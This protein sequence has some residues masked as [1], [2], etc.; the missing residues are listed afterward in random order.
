M[1]QEEQNAFPEQPQLHIQ[2]TVEPQAQ[3]VAEQ[4]SVE[5]QPAFEQQPVEQQ[6]AFEQPMPAQPA[7][8]PFDP[9]MIPAQPQQ[10]VD[11]AAPQPQAAS[12]PPTP[13]THTSNYPTYEEVAAQQ[14]SRAAAQQEKAR[15]GVSVPAA[16]IIAI[17]VAIIASLV[18][19]Y[20][21][22]FDPT[23][24]FS[25]KEQPAKSESVTEIAKPLVNQDLDQNLANAVAE[26]A[27]PSVV[28]IYTYTEQR[29]YNDIFDL[30]TGRGQSQGQKG[31][32]IDATEQVL[33]GLGSGVIISDD[34]YILT[35][36]H[37]VEG[38]SSLKIE[39]GDEE[40]T[41][42]V[43]GSDPTSDIAVVKVDATDLPAIEIADSTQL[44]VGD[45][46]MAIGSP[47]G[48]EATAT[49]GIISALGR[50]T[51]QQSMSG[52][53]I[54]ANL[55]QTDAA[56]N[57][58]NSGGALVDANGRLIGIN[59]LI[60]SATGGSDG[61]GFAIP[62]T[63]A[64]AVANQI[65]AGKT[66]E[67]AQLG[68][69]LVDSSEKGAH[70]QKVTEGS[71]ADEAGLAS[72]DVIVKVDDEKIDTAAEL[73]YAIAGHLVGDEVK[74]TYQRNGTEKTVDVT[75]KSDSST[76]S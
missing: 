58:G 10:P 26:K 5:P 19:M 55:I 16:I 53:T 72:G 3:P 69:T 67:H 31:D 27:V 51:A 43:V 15:S 52:T 62:S 57:T 44:K 24:L 30:F 23:S 68:V 25:Q 32:S 12:V 34:G 74:I 35:N 41:G 8:E 18:T 29:S 42:T 38:S 45:W 49:T 7:A 50:S 76:K 64:S 75:L 40:Y 17:L 1:S 33:S 36:Y 61:L 54:Y 22:G 13:P 11:Q 63:Y 6:P 47:Y 14:A 39:V 37:V 59:T 70:V 48:Y 9:V 60:S 66:V 73:I 28:C 4:P 71:A 21:I 46:V 20:A 56:I 2:P 65:I